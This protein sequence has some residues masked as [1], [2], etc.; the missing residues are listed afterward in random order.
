[1]ERGI[2]VIS[3]DSGVAKDGRL[4]HLNPS[5]SALIGNTIIKL[6]ADHLPD[7]GDVAILSATTTSTNKNTWIEDAKQGWSHYMDINLV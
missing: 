6:A 3:W 1:M 7:G 4:M 5:S 2:T